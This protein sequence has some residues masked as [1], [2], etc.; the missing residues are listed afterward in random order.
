MRKRHC[1]TIGPTSEADAAHLLSEAQDRFLQRRLDILSGAHDLLSAAAQSNVLLQNFSLD[2]KKLAIDRRSVVLG[3]CAGV[4][5]IALLLGG[6]G[7]D[8]AEALLLHGTSGSTTPTPQ[9]PAAVAGYTNYYVADTS[10]GG[11]D[12][13]NGLSTS[14][15]WATIAHV[16]SALSSA[17]GNIAVNFLSTFSYIVPLNGS[18]TPPTTATNFIAQGLVGATIPPVIQAN[19]GGFIGILKTTGSN[20]QTFQGLNT[21]GDGGANNLAVSVGGTNTSVLHC[22]IHLSTL[23]ATSV[24]YGFQVGAGGCL[25]QYCTIGG[26]NKSSNETV[27]IVVQST[28]CRILNNTIQYMGATSGGNPLLDGFGIHTDGAGTPDPTTPFTYSGGVPTN[29]VTEIGF[30]IVSDC[31]W[32]LPSSFGGGPSG[33]EV[34]EGTRCWVHDNIVYNIT[35]NPATYMG[36]TDFDGIDAG[37][38]NATFTLCERNFVFNCLGGGL[39]TFGNPSTQY[40]PSVVRY[41]LVVNCGQGPNIGNVGVQGENANGAHQWYGNTFVIS[42]ASS[43]GQGGLQSVLVEGIGSAPGF[44]VNNII[45][46]PYPWFSVTYNPNVTS[47]PWVNNN[48]CW[49]G[50]NFNFGGSL[51]Y[52]TYALAQAAAIAGTISFDENGVTGDPLFAQ[53]ITNLSWSSAGGGTGTITT[54]NPHG[55]VGTFT[56]TIDGSNWYNGARPIA[57]NGTFTATVTGANSFTIPLAGPDPTAGGFL[58]SNG[59]W[60]VGTVAATL[61]TASWKLGSVS[62]S[63]YRTGVNVATTFG[64][65]AGSTDFFGNAINP[66]LSNIGCDANGSP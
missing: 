33:V 51:V 39:I 9:W 4:S 21:A 11:S 43:V 40:G 18:F 38:T 65:D 14:T 5:A 1:C 27:G 35:P 50:G 59:T 48:N 55:Q 7:A 46:T 44:F 19:G 64:V 24:G 30:N 54:A 12:S 56:A 10:A 41:N 49:I 23:A 32:N 6:G 16:M 17:T 36:G 66:V 20:P 57:F 52:G 22:G 29:A 37:D 63:C 60:A 34:G 45:L 47:T 62:S 13:N 61:V 25:I 58:A 3:L 8:D 31:G 53:E 15:P 42:A 26:I 28:G 2:K